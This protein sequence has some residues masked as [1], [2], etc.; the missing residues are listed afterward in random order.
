M[1]RQVSNKVNKI[2]N[3]IIVVLLIAIGIYYAKDIIQTSFSFNEKTEEENV[4]NNKE[5]NIYFLDVG[6][7]DSILIQEENKV[8]LIDAGNNA[9]GDNL[10]KYLEKLNIKDIDV[11]VG[12]HPHEDHIGGLDNVI[13]YAN[14]GKIYLPDVTTTTKTFEDVLFAI[15]NKDYT[16]TIP[17]IGEK[18][19]LN[20][21]N[22]EIL[23]TGTNEKDLNESSIVIRLDYF[24]TSYLFMGD[25][26]KSVEKK[27]INKNIQ[28]DVLKVGHHG[29]S[30]ST[31]SNFLDKVNPKYAIISVGKNNKYNHPKE[32]IIDLL[33]KKNIMIYRTDLDGTIKLVSDGNNINIEKIKTEID[34]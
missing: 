15:K 28:V 32:E 17:K 31:S 10:V 1:K 2:F 22:F 26:P 30:Y 19:S 23:Y 11:L 5:L 16:I 34:G 20:N 24:N 13:N 3:K 25:A 12:T 4:S 27:I 14:I 8:M 9:D 21:M 29:S 18:F 6:Q 33:N 7:A